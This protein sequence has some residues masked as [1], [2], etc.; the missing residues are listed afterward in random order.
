MKTAAVPIKRI[1][2]GIF[3]LLVLLASTGC[4]SVNKTMNSWVGSHQS[5]LIQSW[6]PPNQVVSDGAGG[7]V[8]IYSSY[9][10]LG[11][12]PGTINQ[13]GY[14]TTYTAP[15]SRGYERTRMFYVDSKGIIYSWRWQG[16]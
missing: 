1:A 3:F 8:L 9:V 12:T 10:N 7:S 6:G 2:V 11:Q 13:W 4:A 14:T 15:Q 16:Y 5:Q